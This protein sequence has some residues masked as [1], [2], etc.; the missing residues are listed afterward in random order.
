MQIKKRQ[1]TLL[2]VKLKTWW[3]RWCLWCWRRWWSWWFWW[4]WWRRPPASQSKGLINLQLQLI[5]SYQL[6]EYHVLRYDFRLWQQCL[7]R[8]VF[9][10][11]GGAA[12][13]RFRLNFVKSFIV[14]LNWTMNDES[15]TII[16]HWIFGVIFVFVLDSW[17]IVNVN[18]GEQTNWNEFNKR[19][20]N[21]LPHFF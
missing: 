7:Q 6:K 3:C 11:L 10:V 15:T 8:I 13:C 12:Y 2:V 20:I 1:S 16:S 9:S 17:T 21:I 19:P 18:M 14:I 5:Q 4:F